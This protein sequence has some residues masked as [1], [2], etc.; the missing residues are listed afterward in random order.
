MT[1]PKSSP[2]AARTYD[3]TCQTWASYLDMFDPGHYYLF[4]H[5]ELQES[6]AGW[7]LLESR[8]D[9]FEAPGPSTKAFATVVARRLQCEFPHAQ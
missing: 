9:N 1:N 7:E 4:G 6:F 8:Y 2:Y 3:D 5:D